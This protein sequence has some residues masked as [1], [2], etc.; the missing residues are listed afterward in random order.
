SLRSE[1]AI[2]DGWYYANQKATT[3]ASGGFRLDGVDQGNVDIGASAPGYPPTA[4]RVAV[5]TSGPLVIKLTTGTAAVQG[6]VV[7]FPGGEAIPSAEISAVPQGPGAKLGL[8]DGLKITA[9]QSGNFT[10]G[11]LPAGAVRLSAR[12][13]Q[14]TRS[15]S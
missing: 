6:R 9:D 15:Y 4:F 14:W 13:P 1:D 3:D 2:E 12:N 10:L 8:S 11:N 7:R 5:P